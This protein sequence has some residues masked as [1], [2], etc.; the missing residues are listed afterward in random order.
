MVYAVV[1]ILLTGF[2]LE[3]CIHGGAVD[4]R[5]KHNMYGCV[6]VCVCVCVRGM[7]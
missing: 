6:C 3:M 4:L 1:C 2:E 5:A 7:R